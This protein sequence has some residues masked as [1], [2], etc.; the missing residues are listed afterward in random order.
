L[1]LPSSKEKIFQNRESGIGGK[2]AFGGRK[3][4]GGKYFRYSIHRTGHQRV[5]ARGV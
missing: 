2:V 5:V 1:K 4:L 3:I